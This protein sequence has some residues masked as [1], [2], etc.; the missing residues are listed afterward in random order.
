MNSNSA[1]EMA[2]LIDTVCQHHNNNRLFVFPCL[3]ATQYSTVL[4]I[5]SK[6]IDAFGASEYVH[7]LFVRHD[8]ID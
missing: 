4:E 3:C 1:S 2:S 5:V 7:S 8:P 6:Q